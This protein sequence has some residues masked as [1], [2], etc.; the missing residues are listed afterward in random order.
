MPVH[1]VLLPI[2]WG[3]A[4]GLLAAVGGCGSSATTDTGAGGLFSKPI[5]IF[6]KPDWARP[7][8]GTTIG[9]LSPKVPVGPDELVSADGRCSAARVAAAPSVAAPAAAP[10][11]DR[12]VGSVAGDLASAPMPANAGTPP[13]AAAEQPPLT[14]GIALGMTE[15]D[16]VRRAGQPGKVAIGVGDKGGRK[17]VLTYLGGPWPGIYDFADGRLKEITR[18][19]E[20][21]AP[22]KAA[23]KKKTKAA[24]KPKPKTVVQ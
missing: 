1:R 4:A 8:G 22:P 11:A 23:P 2:L 15:C 12:L 21:P 19:P 16:A 13:D 20:P 10:P 17:V 18:A 3:V 14:G 6:A 7:T 9:D 5:D 24:A